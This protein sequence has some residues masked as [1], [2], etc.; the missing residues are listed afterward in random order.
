M[1]NGFYDQTATLIYLINFIVQHYEK[2]RN[3]T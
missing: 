1:L 2:Y 3:F